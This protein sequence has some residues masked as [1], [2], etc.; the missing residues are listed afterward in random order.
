MA[1][2]RI[3]LIIPDMLADLLGA[4]EVLCIADCCEARAFELS[5]EHAIR[6]AERVGAEG[7]R[8]ARCELAPLLNILRA[9]KHKIDCDR[10]NQVWT[11]EEALAW[12]ERVSV[13]LDAAN[14]RAN[15]LA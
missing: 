13:L 5:T 4:C 12:F 15:E 1:K 11:A 2:K 6:W 3:P 10:V 7:T 9:N 14:E 8:Q